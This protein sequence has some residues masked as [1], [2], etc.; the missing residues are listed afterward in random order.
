[1]KLAINILKY[2]LFAALGVGIVYIVFKDVDL[3]MLWT[4]ILSVNFWWIILSLFFAL[5]GYISRAIRWNIL[6]K[7]LGYSPQLHNTFFAMMF[8]YFANLAL[9]RVGEFARCVALHK[10][11]Q[12][13][14][15]KLFGTVI[16]ERVSDMCMLLMLAVAV[17]FMKYDLFG[18]FIHTY[19]I[20]GFADK[21]TAIPILYIIGICIVGVGAVVLVLV[22]RNT[23]KVSR[24]IVNFARGIIDGVLSIYKMKNRT[25]FILHTF[26]IWLMY[27]SMTYVVFFAIDA[28][29]H[30]DMVDGL[31]I[32]II[33]GLGMSAPVQSGLG[34]YH[35][36][37][38][39]ALVLYGLQFKTEGLLRSR[40]RFARKQTGWGITRRP[41]MVHRLAACR[42]GVSPG[43]P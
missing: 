15:D 30:L 31:F 28:T 22:S 26:F 18:N 29:S 24:K 41:V 42:G 6:I 14:V 10:R 16:I 3:H 37:V 35:Y 13:S 4:H 21:V 8:G 32:L 9:P 17:V 1:M 12:V 7:S 23:F 27:W 20:S 36:I 43:G 5:L 38:A 40:V 33:G 39:Q 2:V 34:V 19:V 11:E 25:A